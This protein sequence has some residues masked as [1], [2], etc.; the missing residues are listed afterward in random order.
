MSGHTAAT[1][2]SCMPIHSTKRPWPSTSRP[3]TTR[4]DAWR[5]VADQWEELAD[6]AVPP[7]LDGAAEA[8]DAVETLHDAVR[9]GEPGRARVTAASEI[10]WAIRQRH[11]DAFP[12]S[13]ERVAE[14][15]ADLGERV[16]AIYAAEVDALETTARAIGR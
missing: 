15:F 1:S 2:A 4:R 6:A 16:A 13:D 14:I 9:A 10:S 12:L 8:V 3:S 11:V 5:G 7:D